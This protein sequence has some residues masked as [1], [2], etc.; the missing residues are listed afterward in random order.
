LASIAGLVPLIPDGP[1]YWRF[2]AEGVR[3][4]TQRVW[5]DA[6]VVVQSYGNCLAAVAAMMGLALEELRAEELE[7]ND[8]RYPVLITVFCRKRDVSS[9]S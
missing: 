1:D 7:I 9:Q 2:S 8:P 3:E 5:P 6:D 4:L